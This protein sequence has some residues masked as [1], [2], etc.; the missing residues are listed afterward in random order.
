MSNEG[1]TETKQTKADQ[2]RDRLAQIKDLSSQIKAKSFL[3]YYPATNEVPKTGAEVK[4]DT[5][6]SEMLEVLSIIRENIEDT[7]SALNGFI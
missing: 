7:L 4:H 5:F 1:A 3:L 2:I 6:A